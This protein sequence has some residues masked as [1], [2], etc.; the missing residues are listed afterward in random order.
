M[1]RIIAGKARGTRLV[2][3][4]G[5]DTRPTSDKA[6]EALFSILAGQMVDSHVLDLF[7]GTGQIGLEALSRGASEAVL[8]E[9]DRAAL[10]AI[11]QNLTRTGFEIN[12]RVIPADVS[13]AL[14]ILESEGK[15]FDIVFLD[16][17]YAIAAEILQKLAP[18]L[19]GLLVP[20]GA[21]V[22]LEHDS[23]MPPPLT[24]TNLQLH[25]SC[26]YGTA[27]LSFYQARTEKR[28]E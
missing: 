14:Q 6:K 7:A 10:T 13:R 5:R 20:S 24:V 12:C 9:K 16:P 18:A 22:I 4:T 8:V 26:K 15:T 28:P 2:A 19:S 3:P 21:M 1:P 27:M 25:R 17:P 23:S 11:R